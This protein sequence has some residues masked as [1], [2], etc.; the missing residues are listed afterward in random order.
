MDQVPTIVPFILNPLAPSG[1]RY[2][3]FV[4]NNNNNLILPLKTLIEVSFNIED[5]KASF[6]ISITW[7][8]VAVGSL[9]SLVSSKLFVL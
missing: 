6:Y 5:Y 1:N 3:N 2:Y 4:D 7:N 8:Q 9:Q